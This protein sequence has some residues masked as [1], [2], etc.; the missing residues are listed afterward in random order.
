[1]HIRVHRFGLILF[2]DVTLDRM[3]LQ[4]NAAFNT[5]EPQVFLTIV[6]V[7]IQEKYQ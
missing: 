3:C 2:H 4:A 6:C 5:Q 1:M 7:I